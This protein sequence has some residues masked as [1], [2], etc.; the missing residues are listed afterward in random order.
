MSYTVEIICDRLN[1]DDEAV[2]EFLDRV[3]AEDR[4][5]EPTPPILNLYQQVVARFP[6]ITENPEGPWSDGP[7]IENFKYPVTILGISFSRVEEVLPWLVAT[8]N[9]AGFILYD[10]QEDAI[11]R[12]DGSRS[13]VLPQEEPTDSAKPWW[14][15]W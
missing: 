8:V 14:R 9:A 1:G 13:Q 2:L 12:P 6:C 15:F 10:P 11:Y 7:L 3:E 5:G 4:Y